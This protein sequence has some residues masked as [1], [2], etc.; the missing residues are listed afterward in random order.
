VPRRGFGE[1][2]VATV[3]SARRFQKKRSSGLGKKELTCGPGL[4]ETE[5]EGEAAGLF[6]LGCCW[7]AASGRPGW[8]GFLTLFFCYVSFSI[9]F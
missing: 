9:F 1:E 3:S 2:E 4:A 7:A 8:A 6:P 5:R